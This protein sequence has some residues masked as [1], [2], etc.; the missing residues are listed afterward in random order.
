MTP[1]FGA[2]IDG[3]EDGGGVYPNIV[4]NVGTEWGDEGKG[5]SVEVWNAGDVTEEVPFNEFFLRDPK[6]LTAVVDDG[7]LMGMT[8]GDKGAGRGGKEIRKDVG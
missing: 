6:F 1:D 4:K 7:V 3:G 5:V 8:V 2:K